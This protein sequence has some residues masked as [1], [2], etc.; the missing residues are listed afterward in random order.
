MAGRISEGF[1]VW[2]CRFKQKVNRYVVSLGCDGCGN[3]W[4]LSG[5]REFLRKS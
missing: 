2:S 4:I 1:E 5:I 3:L